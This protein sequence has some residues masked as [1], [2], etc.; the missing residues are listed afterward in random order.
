MSL[1]N[2]IC[3]YTRVIEITATR[4]EHL[5]ALNH[6]ISTKG[7]TIQLPGKEE[8]GECWEVHDAASCNGYPVIT[9]RGL[10][11]RAARSAAVISEGFPPHI[12]ARHKCDNPSCVRPEH[13]FWGSPKENAEDRILA[14]L[15]HDG[16]TKDDV[17]DIYTRAR[18]RQASKSELAKEFSMPRE[19]I[20]RIVS[21]QTY[22]H[23]TNDLQAL[24]DLSRHSDI[25]REQSLDVI[26]GV[27]LSLIFN[28]APN[29]TRD[30]LEKR[31]RSYNEST[32][33]GAVGG[34]GAKVHYETLY[35]Y[36][37]IEKIFKT[38]RHLLSQN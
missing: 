4:T 12:H 17:R 38:I 35:T 19:K 15:Q 16:L 22:G 30:S 26:A 1:N 31:G 29:K 36:K 3:A 34:R 32:Y 8:I 2:E 6:L 11:V 13:L 24:P 37:E 21:G 27:G 20:N 28:Q 18:T 7:V 9:I 23:L 5:N 14:E 10:T 33:R 25:T